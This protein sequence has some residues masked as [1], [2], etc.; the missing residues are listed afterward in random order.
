MRPSK[1]FTA[2]L[3]AALGAVALPAQAQETATWSYQP[4]YADLA[5]LSDA[6][7]L[8]L[9]ARIKKVAELD[10]ARAPGLAPGHA[11]LYIEAETGQLI[12]GSVPIG[13]EVRYLVDVPRDSRGKVPK[14]KKHE[15]LLFAR[16]SSRPGE[17]QLVGQ[18][19][20]LPYTPGLEAQVRPV[21]A[22]LMS[23]QRPPV[24]TGVRDAL[25]VPGNLV[26]ESETQL[27]LD[28]REGNPVSITVT[29]RPNMSP[30]W[31][32]SWSEIVDQ[33]ARA[34]QPGTIEW[35][36]LACALP[37]NLPA[38]AFLGGDPANR[39]QAEEDYRLVRSELGP[40]Q[41]NRPS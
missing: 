20:Q 41:R 10:P 35:Y 24:V 9:R 27:F 32:V 6:A 33:S 16:P 23:A 34:P 1:C 30:V 12:A 22:G 13:E 7:D 17:L 39:A 3:A 36:R 29:R 26:G 18:G 5:D 14:L 31:G 11:R 37:A 8:V 38:E 21:L 28:T 40:C 2:I 4:S 25:S 15:V 19:A